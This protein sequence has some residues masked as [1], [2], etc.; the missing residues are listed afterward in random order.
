[1]SVKNFDYLIGNKYGML[2]VMQ[3]TDDI[4]K[5]NG[6]KVTAYECLCD[7]GR[8]VGISAW[9]IASGHQKS[10]GCLRDPNRMI[11]KKYGMLTVIKQVEDKICPSGN[12]ETRYECVC[13]CGNVTIVYG[14]YLRNGHTKSCGCITKD[15]L[16]AM[17][18]THGKSKSRLY[19]VWK[20]IRS[21]CN[22][23]NNKSYHNYGGRGIKLCDE[24]NDFESFKE[25]AYANGYDENANKN[26]CTIDR[27]DANGDYCP[28]NCRWITTKEQNSNKR[29]NHYIELDGVVHTITQWCDIYGIHVGTVR[30]RLKCGWSEMDAITIKPNYRKRGSVADE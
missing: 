27:I 7:C 23:P 5:K 12:H 26:Q 30:Q 6:D 2:T 20:G 24:W 15:R 17:H 21:R 9:A 16:I 25:W 8:I 4:I 14:N 10:C 22:N 28:E 11:G 13:D 29:N 18:K 1:M 19:K 3:K